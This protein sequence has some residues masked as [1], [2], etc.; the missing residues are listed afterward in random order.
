MVKLKHSRML[1]VKR[2]LKLKHVEGSM[3]ERLEQYLNQ[4]KYGEAKVE[5]I[6][7][8]TVDIVRGIGLMIVCVGIIGTV[9][10]Y[11]KKKRGD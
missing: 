5:G 9:I 6:L 10:V 4:G 8:Y 3:W 7:P 2:T 1:L 11:K